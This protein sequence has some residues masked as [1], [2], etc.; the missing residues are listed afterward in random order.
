MLF[1]SPYITNA[2]IINGGQKNL[3]TLHLMDFGIIKT[4]F[5]TVLTAISHNRRADIPGATYF[6]T[7]ARTIGCAERREAPRS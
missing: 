1:C 2:L 6:F 5:L 4:A 3:P 7:A